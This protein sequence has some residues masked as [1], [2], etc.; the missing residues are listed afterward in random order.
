MK[1]LTVLFLAVLAAW[2]LFALPAGAAPTY[3]ARFLKVAI[4]YELH[5]DGSWDMTYEHRV[6]LDTYYAVN[7]ALGETFIVYDPAFQE[8]EV[9]RSETTMADGRKVA[10]P[11]NAFN[12]VLPFAAHGFADFSGLREMVVTHTGL[13]RGAVVELRYRV[14]TRPG[15][16]PAFSGS[17]TLT[18][19]FPVAAC[20]LEIVVP[21]GRELRYHVFGLPAE[22]KVDASGT[23]TRYAFAWADLPAATHEAFSQAGSEPA[24]VFSTAADWP[25]AL[26]LGDAPAPLPAAVTARVDRMKEQCPDRRD[27]LA[28]L[29]KFVAG[30]VENCRLGIEA[31][32]WRPRPPAQ[33]ASSNYGTGLEKALLLQAVL[34]RAG[35]A[36][37][38]LAVASPAFDREVPTALQA[39][40]FWLKV[41]GMPGAPE[42]G[43]LDPCRE[44]EEFFPYGRPGLDAY[45]VDRRM[46]EILPTAGWERSGVDVS[47]TA[48]LDCDGASGTLEVAVRGVF[49]RYAEAAA[50]SGKFIAG[51][52]KQFFPVEK[53]EIKKLLALTRSEV[54]AEVTF[55]GKWLKEAG[56]GFLGADAVGLPGL[57]DNMVIPADRESPMLIEAPFR[58]SLELELRPA[59]GLKLAYA[60]PDVERENET[61]FFSRRLVAEKDGRLRFFEN[62][63]I[64]APLITPDKYP[65]LREALMPNFI[66]DFWLVFKKQK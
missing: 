35:F 65:L 4:A 42:G 36:S 26:A 43:Y 9:L 48:Q 13:E 34:K 46:L 54:R 21:A 33:V 45:N 66:P 22:A 38:L 14:H 20:D 23:G 50:D 51:L 59:A 6:R 1:R 19:N 60:A 2:S 52:L 47:G 11:E 58:V 44:Q 18:R 61:G 32:G 28:A 16:L 40:E 39:N 62:C 10:S 7:R 12:E 3:D 55:S 56:T 17:E 64:A 30:E 41:P 63:G 29:Q 27:L 5:D 25:Q 24:I 15:F 57:S 37:E 31:T 53:V 49:Q 8:L